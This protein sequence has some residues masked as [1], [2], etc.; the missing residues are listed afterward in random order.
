MKCFKCGSDMPDGCAF[1]RSCGAK[2]SG[3]DNGENIE[4]MFAAAISDAADKK[5]PVPPAD[6]AYQN[7]YSGNGAAPAKK[8]FNALVIP[9][10]ILAVLAVALGAIT[11]VMVGAVGEKDD[12]ISGY[13]D[14]VSG[15]EAEMKELKTDVKDLEASVESAEAEAEEVKGQLATVEGEKKKIESEKSDIQNKYDELK[16]KHDGCGDKL[17]FFDEHAV[18][19]ADDGTGIYHRYGCSYLDVSSFWIFNTEYADYMEYT[20][21]SH[22]I[23]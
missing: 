15:L 16:E 9:V 21:C 2:L 11:A 4:K 18:V 3:A 12:K 23:G 19:I 10:I 8:K 20:P 13:K 1:C 5:I 7:G 17:D 14:Q 22:C 6:P